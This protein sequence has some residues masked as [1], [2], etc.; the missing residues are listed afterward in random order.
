MRRGESL[1]NFLVRH[2]RDENAMRLLKLWYPDVRNA[3]KAQTSCSYADNE[4]LYTHVVLPEHMKLG[5]KWEHYA[6]HDP[7]PHI[8]L[9]RQ[10]KML[11]KPH[12]ATPDQSGRLPAKPVKTATS[13]QA[14]VE[15]PAARQSN[16][17]ESG[18]VTP[19][20]GQKEKLAMSA[21]DALPAGKPVGMTPDEA[22]AAAGLSPKLFMWQIPELEA[23]IEV[24]EFVVE[25]GVKA[26]WSEKDLAT[27]LAR[28]VC[29]CRGVRGFDGVRCL[30][31]WVKD[32]VATLVDDMPMDKWFQREAAHVLKYL[33]KNCSNSSHREGRHAGLSGEHFLSALLTVPG[34]ATTVANKL[35]SVFSRV[36]SGGGMRRRG[37]AQW[38]MPTRML[39]DLLVMAAGH[40]PLALRSSSETDLTR[41]SRSVASKSCGMTRGVK[42]KKSA[43]NA[44][45]KAKV[46]K[47]K[48]KAHSAGKSPKRGVCTMSNYNAMDFGRWITAWLQSCRS[49]KAELTEE[50]FKVMQKAQAAGAKE[51]AESIGVKTFKDFM[52]K[53]SVLAACA[54]R[55]HGPP[56]LDPDLSWRDAGVSWVGVFV[57]LCEISGVCEQFR[58]VGA[59]CAKAHSQDIGHLAKLYQHSVLPKHRQGSATLSLALALHEGEIAPEAAPERPAKRLLNLKGKAKCERC[60]SVVRRDVIARHQTSDKCKDAFAAKKKKPKSSIQVRKCRAA[61]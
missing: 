23:G 39:K 12:S 32:N 3:E 7:E 1:L 49:V 47:T 8:L 37:A 26:Q 24:L 60:G 55:L 6:W 34:G 20:S 45:S 13:A 18:G 58:D 25:E 43:G 15:P 44:K 4:Y 5:S 50:V 61:A 30:H 27:G 42:G 28:T 54:K 29:L 22:L 31:D 48:I 2:P 59:L 56:R 21:G 57:H 40:F 11:S 19:A 52:H 9:F 41:G 46:K 14:T 53:W 33:R 17:S 10:R 38:E 36:I 35:V 51:F 16:A